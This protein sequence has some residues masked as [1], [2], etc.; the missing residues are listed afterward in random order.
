[1][2]DS[3]ITGRPYHP[4]PSDNVPD[5]DKA[6]RNDRHRHSRSHNSDYSDSQDDDIKHDSFDNSEYSDFSDESTQSQEDPPVDPKV[7]VTSLS[8]TVVAVDP[9]LYRR[10]KRAKNPRSRF[11]AAWWFVIYS[12]DKRA[13]YIQHLVKSGFNAPPWVTFESPYGKPPYTT[14]WGNLAI[15]LPAISHLFKCFAFKFRNKP[16]FVLS[17]LSDEIKFFRTYSMAMAA[18]FDKRAIAEAIIAAIDRWHGQSQFT[19][20]FIDALTKS[21]FEKVKMNH[22]R[23]D[24]IPSGNYSLAKGCISPAIFQ[25][26]ARDECTGLVK[27]LS[28]NSKKPYTRPQSRRPY[29]NPSH[30]Y[31]NN[32]SPSRSP[33]NYARPPINP[34]YMPPRSVISAHSAPTTHQAL[35]ANLAPSGIPYPAKSS[36]VLPVPSLDKPYPLYAPRLEYFASAAD[37]PTTPAGLARSF[38]DYLTKLGRCPPYYCA[39]YQV[40][41]QCTRARCDFHHLCEWCASKAHT[42]NQCPYRPKSI[43]FRKK[44]ATSRPNRSLQ[45]PPA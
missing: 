4:A 1:M 23:V 44:S 39:D 13:D 43:G 40:N 10:V 42:G 33:S 45:A 24:S 22:Y 12:H 37:F 14:Q 16:Q 29:F 25:K 2:F 7:V 9:Q 36:I 3:Q 28:N 30:N 27:K 35:P 31:Y 8:N 20:L 6:T 34:S 38:D 32:Y 5:F 18:L 15:T 21:N 19:V 41:G 17:Y 11:Q 26:I